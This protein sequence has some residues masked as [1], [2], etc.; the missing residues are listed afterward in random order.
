MTTKNTKKELYIKCK[1][2]GSEI[3]WNTKKVVISCT[4]GKV[5]VDGCEGYIRILANE[6][7]Y[8]QLKK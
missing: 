6:G 2:C 8:I 4:C 1:S 5:G 7:D 3:F